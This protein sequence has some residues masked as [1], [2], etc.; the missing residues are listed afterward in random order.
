MG[1]NGGVEPKGLLASVC[2]ERSK[3]TPQQRVVGERLVDDEGGA[4]GVTTPV[5]SADSHPSCW[6]WVLGAEA[7]TPELNRGWRYMGARGSR[8]VWTEGE[9]GRRG[10][11]EVGRLAP[12]LRR[13]G[14][15]GVP[16]RPP[17]FGFLCRRCCEGPRIFYR[18]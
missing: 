13:D 18:G 3:E 2:R 12:G 1:W 14:S 4:E 6:C 17:P 16:P 15:R 10:I 8:R 5:S 9:G 11:E 7:R